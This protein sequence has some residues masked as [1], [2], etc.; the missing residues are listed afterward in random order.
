MVQQFLGAPV[1]LEGLWT[2]LKEMN[3]GHSIKPGCNCGDKTV[4]G[5]PWAGA[6]C[7]LF[8]TQTAPCVIVSL[9]SLYRKCSNS[10][11]YKYGMRRTEAVCESTNF[12]CKLIM[13]FM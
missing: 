7:R 10:Q 12:I 11:S 4:F 8:L 5:C 9:L 2:V 6:N 1:P 3:G 13:V